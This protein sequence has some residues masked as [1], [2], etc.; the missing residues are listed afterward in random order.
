MYKINDKVKVAEDN[1]NENYDSFRNKNLIVT[2]IAT[3]VN[4]HPGYDETMNGMQLM[5]FTDE[6]G[7][8]IP[9]S[10]YEYEITY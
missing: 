5:D 2:H 6:Q 9:C 8:E 1:D 10:L 4:D 7:N 3:N